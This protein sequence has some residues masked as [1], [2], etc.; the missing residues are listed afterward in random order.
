VQP[1]PPLDAQAFIQKALSLLA[2]DRYLEKGMAPMALTGHRLG[3]N[4]FLCQLQFAKKEAPLSRGY[5]RGHKLLGPNASL[6]VRQS[7]KDFYVV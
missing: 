4:L 5:L 6:S 3:R 2:S 1:D 7:Y